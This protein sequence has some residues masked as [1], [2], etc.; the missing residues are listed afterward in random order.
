MTDQ[1]DQ[2]YYTA[3]VSDNDFANDFAN[4]FPSAQESTMPDAP[5]RPFDGYPKWSGKDDEFDNFLLAILSVV[6]DPGMKTHLGSDQHVCSAIFSR[7]PGHRQGEVSSYFRD[8][9]PDYSADPT[10]TGETPPFVIE[11]FMR[12][13]VSAFLPK[14]IAARAQSKIY[15]IRQGPAQPVHS[16]TADFNTLC[17]RAGVLAPV[18]AARVQAHKTALNAIM[19]EACT[20]R[21]FQSNTDWDKYIADVL[22]TGIDIE[23][24]PRFINAKGSKVSQFADSQTGVVLPAATEVPARPATD[25]VDRD[26]D[27]TMGGV[28]AFATTTAAANS[29]DL[30]SMVAAAVVQA[31]RGSPTPSNGTRAQ[32]SPDTRPHPPARTLNQRAALIDAGSCER[33]AVTPSHPWSQCRFRNFRENPTQRGRGRSPRVNNVAAARSPSSSSSGKE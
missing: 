25:R 27:I 15:R 10:T 7:I 21:G 13:L 23:K 32:Y 26:G 28:N 4:A 3:D 31:M 29:S 24:L 12:A 14:D 16:F 18:G 1:A 33:C 20:I 5:I 22:R 11:D 19:L 6:S 30:V 9:L 17:A 8:R 2:L